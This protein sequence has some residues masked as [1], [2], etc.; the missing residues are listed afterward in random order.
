M[1]A[2]E[3]VVPAQI[4]ARFRR[5]NRLAREARATYDGMATDLSHWIAEENKA[6]VGLASYMKNIKYEV[7]D[8]G[9]VFE[10]KPSFVTTRTPDGRLHEQHGWRRERREDLDRIIEP[11]WIARRRVA[12]LREELAFVGERSQAFG[13]AL[14]AAKEALRTRFPDLNDAATWAQV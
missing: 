14:S 7:G 5:L 6:A 9:E 11:L 4:L 3:D 10:L 12:T 8:K 1:R 2:I 13:R